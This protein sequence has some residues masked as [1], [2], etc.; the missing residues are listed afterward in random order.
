MKLNIWC[1]GDIKEW[2]INLDNLK[3]GWIDVVHNLETFPYPFDDNSFDEIFCS[4]I[5]EHMSDLWK[6]ME[7][8]TRIG[9]NGCQIKVKVPY[10]SSP[11]A[12]WDYTHKRTFNTNSFGYFHP[13]FFYNHWAKIIIKSYKIHFF[14]I[15]NFYVLNILILYLTFL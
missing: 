8:L 6:T 2:Y 11:N 13:D 5:L 7:E 15:I 3:L 12:R 10:F 4:H 14:L 9:K 1:G